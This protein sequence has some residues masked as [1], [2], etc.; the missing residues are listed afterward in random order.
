MLHQCSTGDSLGTDTTPHSP[1]AA[2][3]AMPP[4][5][6]ALGL[7]G[8]QTTQLLV[9]PPWTP[10]VL[11]DRVT[12]T[13]QGSGTAGATT[14]YKDGKRWLQEGPDCLIVTK[15]GTYWCDRPGT[16]LSPSVLVVNGERSLFPH[17]GTCGSPERSGLP[18]LHGVTPWCDQS[19]SPAHGDIRGPHWSMSCVH[20]CTQVQRAHPVVLGETLFPLLPLG[21]S[22]PAAIPVLQVPAWAL[23]EG[24]TVTLRCWARQ[25]ESNLFVRFY[26][27]GTGPWWPI[28]RTELPLP[29]LQL[30]HSGSRSCSVCRRFW[31]R[32]SLWQ[33][34]AP[35]T[36]TVHK[37]FTV[38]VLQGP[39]EVSEGSPLTLICLSTP[40]PLR[41]RAPLLHLFYRDG[42][43]VGGLQGSPQLLVPAVGVSHSGSYSCQVPSE[44]GAVRKSSAWLGVTVRSEH[45]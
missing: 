18:Q 10:A 37:L 19:P 27:N 3:P 43:L 11:W 17:P 8:A 30:H 26:H 12:L 35:V 2:V 5:A 13:C 25:E 1:G 45:R 28:R 9:E 31:P 20:Q 15:T 7:A 6:L 21:P 33:E 16:R 24:D 34:S 39:P 41:P 32:S 14:W 38:P 42:Q 44:S 40:S 29:P 22:C 4:P 23:L 36:V